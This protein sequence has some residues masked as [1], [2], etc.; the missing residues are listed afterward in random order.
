MQQTINERFKIIV[1]RWYNGND[2]AFAKSMGKF[3]SSFSKIING[4]VNPRAATLQEVCKSI[5]E[6]NP[7]WLLMGEGAIVRQ[8]KDATPN[9]AQVYTEIIKAKQAEMKAK[10]ELIDTLKQQVEDLRDFNRVLRG[11]SAKK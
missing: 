9:E 2:L 10:D 11:N 4:T 6:L 3:S 5:P 1:E 8:P 7:S